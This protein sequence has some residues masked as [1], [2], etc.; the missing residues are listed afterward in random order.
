MLCQRWVSAAAVSAQLHKG[1]VL[2][3]RDA[4]NSAR[5]FWACCCAVNATTEIMR[6]MMACVQA[7]ADEIGIPFLETSAKNATNVEQAFMTMAAEIKNRMASQPMPP[8]P[9]GPG[10][11]RP[12]EGKPV[13]A[14]KSG[15]C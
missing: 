13:G 2:A 4:H 6:I 14:N 9:G 3:A 12:G 11:I 1:V 10:T 8:R 5:Q 7:F 15:C